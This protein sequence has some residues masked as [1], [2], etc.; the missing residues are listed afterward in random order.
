MD[1]LELKNILSLCKGIGASYVSFIPD[2]ILAKSYTAE[3][4]VPCTAGAAVR[5][6]VP[7]KLLLAASAGLHGD[8]VNLA[9]QGSQLCL[10]AG[11]SG[12]KQQV[13]IGLLRGES[14]DLFGMGEIEW[15]VC[16]KGF[17]EAL[18]QAATAASDKVKSFN[19]SCVHIAVQNENTL[20]V[21]GCNNLLAIRSSVAVESVPIVTGFQEA[22]QGDQAVCLHKQA[23]LSI[24][25]FAPDLWTIHPYYV[26]FAR[27]DGARLLCARYE[28]EYPSLE[29]IFNTLELFS[30]RWIQIPAEVAKACKAGSAVTSDTVFHLMLL[31]EGDL[32]TLVV[33]VAT[34]SASY[35][36]TFSEVLC[37]LP[38][39]PFDFH[40]RE[41]LLRRLLTFSTK[42]YVGDVYAGAQSIVSACVVGLSR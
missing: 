24:E 30:S 28:A 33:H 17:V 6:D 13:L 32:R 7:L 29:R 41:D 4:F 3:L 26:G 36:E 37:Q 12:S 39:G 21:Q 35:E 10:E 1:V 34:S 11:G 27:S 16:P 9:M 8:Q 25:K 40:M 23:V 2:G 14:S 31:G 42:V 38:E 15:H 18:G 22:A 20:Q 19:F 5:G